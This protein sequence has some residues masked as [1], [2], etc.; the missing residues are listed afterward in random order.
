M[1]NPIHRFAVT[2][3]A[4][5]LTISAATAASPLTNSIGMLLVRIEPGSFTMGQDGPAADYHMTKHPS[6]CDD[7][8]WDERP[9]H[10]VTISA[11]FFR[12]ATTILC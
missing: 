7:A 3:V 6:K 11:P 2:V 8:D 10:R 9:V 4:V 1:E 12:K 5:V